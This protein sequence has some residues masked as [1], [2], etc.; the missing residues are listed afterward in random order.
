M[1]VAINRLDSQATEVEQMK[2][3]ARMFRAARLMRRKLQPKLVVHDEWGQTIANP[4]ACA[5]GTS[6]WFKR[7]F[8]P[9]NTQGVSACITAPNTPLSLIH[10]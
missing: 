5:N 1:N 3:S 9:V 7:L 10:I 8:A 6:Q 4:E 2:D